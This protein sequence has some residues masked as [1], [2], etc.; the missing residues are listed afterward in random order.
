MI[1]L[2]DPV[3]WVPESP[4]RFNRTPNCTKVSVAAL[5]VNAVSDEFATRCDST[6]DNGAQT[7]ATPDHAWE[8]IGN[9]GQAPTSAAGHSR[10]FSMPQ[11][12]PVFPSS[13]R[14][15]EGRGFDAKGQQS[16]RGPLLNEWIKPKRSLRLQD[17]RH[18]AW[19]DRST[20]FDLSYCLHAGGKNP[21]VER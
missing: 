17:A 20:G 19:V 7:T 2:S 6:K 13:R 15:S 1:L 4:Q 14:Q 21:T 12:R 9:F 3:Q 8:R 18:R 10:K 16:T 11:S 5:L